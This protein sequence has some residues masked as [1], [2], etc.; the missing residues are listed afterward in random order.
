MSKR[1]P[2]NGVKARAQSEN[3]REGPAGHSG[4]CQK[5]EGPSALGCGKLG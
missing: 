4:Y 5:P 3:S 1:K 2:D